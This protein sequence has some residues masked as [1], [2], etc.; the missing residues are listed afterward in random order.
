MIFLSSTLFFVDF[1]SYSEL[2]AV[3][4]TPLRYL[5]LGVQAASADPAFTFAFLA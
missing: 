2:S 4:G 1:V 5:G 3:C